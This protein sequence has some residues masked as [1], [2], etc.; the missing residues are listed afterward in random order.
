MNSGLSILDIVLIISIIFPSFFILIKCWNS[1]YA[2]ELWQPIVFISAYFV[3]Y[4]VVSPLNMIFKCD[5]TYAHFS[6][7][8]VF[9]QAWCGAALSFLFICLGYY[10]PVSNIFQ[11][12]IRK[13]I[14]SLK[15]ISLIIILSCS[16]FY[17]AS[18]L[19]VSSMFSF[20]NISNYSSTSESASL[21]NYLIGGLN[22]SIGALCFFQAYAL[23][24]KKKK[25]WLLYWILFEIVLSGILIAGFRYRLV[26]LTI[27]SLSIYFLSRRKRPSI[28][29]GIAASI[30]FIIFMG[31]IEKGRSYGRGINFSRSIE[32]SGEQLFNSGMNDTRTFFAGGGYMDYVAKEDAYAYFDPIINA[33]CR[34]IPRSIFPWKPD[35]SYMLKCMN[36]VFGDTQM[37][38]EVPCYVEHYISFGWGGIVFYGFIFGVI[39]R[40]FW[41]QFLKQRMNIT[42]VVTVALFNG[43]TYIYLSRGYMAAQVE[44]FF[45]IVIIP[46]YLCS[47][48]KK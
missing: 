1:S 5:A 46:V 29:L 38:V 4:T 18:G 12:S 19:S 41:I 15:Y 9:T 11:F 25:V 7:Y 31:V 35:N 37:G 16:I 8:G 47:S 17:F 36:G 45:F 3:Y 10:S 14:S 39:A 48:I 32:I 33:I 28:I 43:Y 13:E 23:R 40:F 6:A 27:S 22:V 44:N 34:P 26:I 20:G 30:F 24:E 2:N 21:K 42:N